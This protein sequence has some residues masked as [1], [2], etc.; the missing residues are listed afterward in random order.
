MEVRNCKGCGR[1]FNYS[2]GTPLC[3]ACMRELEDKFHEVK[4]YIY[5]N[6]GAS[7]NQVAEENE[8]SIQQLKRWVREERLEFSADSAVGLEC[9]GC[10][11]IIRTGR[12]CGL[13]KDKLATSLGS[14]YK[15]EAP[16]TSSM[17]SMKDG[18]KMRFF[19]K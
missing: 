19:E 5:D 2:A 8:V 12:Y 16:V 4:Q 1:L 15:A 7:I 11:K 18:A 9:E 17:N 6:P 14:A 3:P 10:G 13:C